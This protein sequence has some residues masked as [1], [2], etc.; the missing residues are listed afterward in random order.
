MKKTILLATVLFAVGGAP[1]LSGCL[2]SGSDV[3]QRE[4]LIVQESQRLNDWFEA[5]YEEGIARSPMSRTY[6]G[7]A[8][9]KDQLDA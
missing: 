5:R 2:G 6:L 7:M 3:P 9:G 1:L 8:D 4:E